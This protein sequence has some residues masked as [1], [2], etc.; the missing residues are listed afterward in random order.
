MRNLLGKKFTPMLCAILVLAMAFA[1]LSGAATAKAAKSLAKIELDGAVNDWMNI[2]DILSETDGA[3]DRVAAFYDDEYVYVLFMLNDV[4]GWEHSQVFIDLDGDEKTGFQDYGG[5]FEFMVENANLYM[6][7]IGEWPNTEV[8]EIEMGRSD[9][10]AVTEYRVARSLLKYKGKDYDLK[11]ATFNI[12]LRDASWNTAFTYPND[13]ITK[14]PSLKDATIKSD[15]PGISGFAFKPAKDMR[16]LTSATLPGGTIGSFSAQGGD[17]KK[18]SYSFAFSA[19]KGK[20]NNK[21]VIKGNKLIVGDQLLGPGTYKINLKVKSGIRSEIKAFDVKIKKGENVPITEDIFDGKKGEWFTVKYNK[22]KK[23]GYEIDAIKTQ[24]RLYTMLSAKEEDLDTQNV[25]ILDTKAKAG[26]SYKGLAGADYVVRNGVLY[27]VAAKDTVG[28]RIAAADI[29]Y[30]A[31]NVT[32]KLYLKDLGNPKKVKIAVTAKDDAVKLPAKKYLEVKASFK[33][34]YDKNKVYPFEDFENYSNPFEGYGVWANMNMD[35]AENLAYN[36]SLAYLPISWADAVPTKGK[37]DWKNIEETYNFD[38]WKKHGVKFVF[39]FII[40]NPEPLTG[41]RAEEIYGEAVDKKFM[42]KY[43][44]LGSDGKAS[45]EAVEKL[46]AT[47]DFRMDIPVW[48]F[49]ELCNETLAGTTKNAGTFYNMYSSIGGAGFSP[50]YESKIMINGHTELFKELAKKLDDTS[51]TAY[52]EIGS[53]GHWGEFHTWPEKESPES[54]GFGSGDFPSEAVQKKYINA[55][56]NN[57]KNVKSGTRNQGAFAKKKGLGLFNDVTG[58]GKMQISMMPDFWKKNY[59]GGEFANGDSVRYLNNEN[60][61]K[62]LGYIK[63]AHTS[64]QAPCSPADLLGTDFDAFFYQTNIN[65]LQ[66]IMGYRFRVKDASYTKSAKAGSSLKVS[67]T[68]ENTGIAPIYYNYPVELS[69]LDKNGKVVAKAISKAD[70]TTCMP[71]KTITATAN[72]KIP[73]SAKGKLTVACAIVD[74]ATKKPA[75][76]LA[77]RA[78]DANNRIDLYFIEITK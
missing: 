28:E 59:S 46:L 76:R 64:W 45:A 75:I 15:E 40:D 68:I 51:I 31:D 38:Y 55:Y 52:A 49:V 50:N 73:A 56:L 62:T 25:W 67:V 60:F 32:M 18:Y 27:K 19:V 69:L 70:L 77:N 5:G 63:D 78:V 43:S 33:M 39:R 37:V 12:T 72:I 22:A 29:D 48:L 1:S 57:F 54:E 44:L 74:P 35:N 23:N 17:G 21:F 30:A 4:T 36:Y 41:S 61:L 20:D 16:A 9:D 7:E 11:N 24:Y 14:L 53:L 71:G 6:T 66:R 2:K 47:G 13:S 10:K 3:F 34:S 8:D 42:E 58:E 65:Y 26:Y